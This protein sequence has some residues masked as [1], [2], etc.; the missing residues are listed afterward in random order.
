MITIENYFD[1]IK[2]IDT[3]NF[4]APM[5]A[6]HDF[7]VKATNGGASLSAYH[8]SPGIKKTLDLYLTK[9]NEF[10]QADKKG[11]SKE[12]RQK[13]FIR[14]TDILKPTEEQEPVKP[15]KGRG[16]RKAVESERETE[17]TTKVTMVER[18]PEEI[19][20]IKR[21]V[22]MHGKVKTKEEILRFINSL[23]KA[24]VE[25]R[26]RK[27]SAWAGQIAL[28]QDYLIAEY[29][30][31]KVKKLVHL[32]S[33]TV[34]AFTALVQGEKVL[35]SVNFIKRYISISGKVGM[36]QKA[37]ALLNQIERAAKKNIISNSD[38]YHSQIHTVVNNL[39]RFREDKK[40]KVLVI[41]KA[42]LNGLQGILGCACQPYNGLGEVP[43]VMNS[44]DFANMTFETIGFTGKWHDFIGDPSP[45][46]TAMVFGRPKYGK[47]YLCVD[48][49]G[50]LAR[51]H[52]KVLYVAKEEG[53]ETT[54]QTKLNDKDVKHPNLFVA[55]ELVEDLS[56]YDFV[57]LDSVTRLQLTPKDLTSM[58]TSN[59]NKS[60][61]YIF[62]TTKE[63]KSRGTNEYLHNVDIVIEVPE[64]G[65]A[66]Q[67]GRFNQGGEMEIFADH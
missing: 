16:R 48:F 64:P 28:I 57:F 36:K 54:L 18:I 11:K 46:F 1:E 60:F 29:N 13:P 26:I 42:E 19:K 59:P 47:S 52:G 41:E 31:M 20:F 65:R 23:Q 14:Q 63:G 39:R 37:I 10:V 34:E 27:T 56:L 35:P 3:G 43:A 66:V 12:K 32:K 8:S 62:Q 50:Y 30:S 22:N 51:N 5:I 49:A 9:V 58:E 53:L 67:Y 2:N 24:I 55:A 44:M 40:S 61:V 33:E 38:P 6:G 25:K 21:L 15:E 7:M 45:N 4:P 17:P